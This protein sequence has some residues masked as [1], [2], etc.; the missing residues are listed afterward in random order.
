MA[1]GE[2]TR[3]NAGLGDSPWD[4]NRGATGIGNNAGLTKMQEFKIRN[5]DG[6]QVNGI[7]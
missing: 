6:W 1:G 7:G 2:T 4:A 5:G 3:G